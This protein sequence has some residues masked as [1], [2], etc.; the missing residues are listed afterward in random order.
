MHI[1]YFQPAMS[2]MKE[3][4]HQTSRIIKKVGLLEDIVYLVFK[5]NELTHEKRDPM[6]FWL[7]VFQMHVCSPLFGL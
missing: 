4:L 6:V 2:E 5:Y 3:A 1:L 7:V